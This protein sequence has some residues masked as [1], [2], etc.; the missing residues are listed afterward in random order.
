MRGLRLLVAISAIIFVLIGTLGAV[1]AGVAGA[2]F[3]HYLS[4]ISPDSFSVQFSI[5]IVMILAVG[6]KDSLIGAFFGAIAVT[7]LP[8]LLAGYD[9]YSELVFGILFL[10]TV[11]FMPR[12]LA[13]FGDQL[14]ARMKGAPSTKEARD[15]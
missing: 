5:L 3:V 9:K 8:I 11:M 1:F 13:G 4:F 15:G 2:L 12:G 10:S 7:V 6:G 14:L